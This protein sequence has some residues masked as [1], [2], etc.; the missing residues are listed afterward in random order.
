MKKIRTF[1]SLIVNQ[2]DFDQKAW[3]S[4]T[5]ARNL[6]LRNVCF[7][8]KVHVQRAAVF[9]GFKKVQGTGRRDSALS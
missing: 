8:I 6:W 1:F 2:A 3:P 7:L 4:G 9:A 5:P